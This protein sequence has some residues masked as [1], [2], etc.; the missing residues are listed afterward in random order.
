MPLTRQIRGITEFNQNLKSENA[1]DGDEESD[2]EHHHDQ[3][4]LPLV[5]LHLPEHRHMQAQNND[6]QNDVKRGGRPALSINVV[7]AADVFFIPMSPSERYR[8]ALKDGHQDK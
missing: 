1:D 6:V 3:E 7:A 8:P 5:E 4:L 2:G